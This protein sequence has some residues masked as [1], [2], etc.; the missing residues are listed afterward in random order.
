M[1]SE[2]SIK[3]VCVAGVGGVGGFY[4]GMLVASGAAEVSFLARGEHLAAIRRQGLRLDTVVREGQPLVCR[5]RLATDSLNEI[6]GVDLFLVAVKSY[7]LEN[8]ARSRAPLVSDQTIILPLLNGVD[9]CERLRLHIANGQVLPAC[10]YLGSRI[11]APGHV[12]QSAGRGL[13]VFGPDPLRPDF[14]PR[15]LCTL[16]E[17][18][19]IPFQWQDDAAAAI[20]TKYIFIAA[21]GLVSAW[22]KKTMG[23]IRADSGLNTRTAEVMA[24]IIALARAREIALPEDILEISL[25]KADDFPPQTTTSYQRDVAGETKA[26]EG[27]LFG[28]TIL[29]LGQELGLPVPVTRR[30]YGEIRGES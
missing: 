8:L 19:G 28:G 29:R 2:N 30:L 3:T 6:G 26:D 4:G 20:W 12:I 24:E 1:S 27:D 18:A 10:V 14:D 25:R 16:L 23:E 11:E 13:L 17:G 5:P 9:I 22:S 15:P 7:D 21:F